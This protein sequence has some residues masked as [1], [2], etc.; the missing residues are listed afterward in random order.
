M[1]NATETEGQLKREE[2]KAGQDS[3]DLGSLSL[4]PARLRQAY[5]RY[6]GGGERAGQL[7][8]HDKLKVYDILSLS[9]ED[10]DDIVFLIE[11]FTARPAG[12]SAA[13]VAFQNYLTAYPSLLGAP[14]DRLRFE[15]VRGQLRAA[16]A[17]PQLAFGAYLRSFVL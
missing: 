16:L 12:A 2:L 5:E 10:E 9:R 7:H 6:V 13:E 3:V 11:R 14:V 4:R 17:I 1:R 8:R 15:A